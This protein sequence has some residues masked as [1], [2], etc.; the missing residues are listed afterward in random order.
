MKVNE[1]F[2]DG[3]YLVCGDGLSW[4]M[5][6]YEEQSRIDG[7]NTNTD[8]PSSLLIDRTA[9]W[10]KNGLLHRTNGPAFIS[11][12]GTMWWYL[13]NTKYPFEEFIK[14]TPITNEEKVELALRYG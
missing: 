3:S 5:Q 2:S 4:Y 7:D 14:I 10:R 8:Y 13:D 1:Y 11:R 9:Y 6:R 12:D